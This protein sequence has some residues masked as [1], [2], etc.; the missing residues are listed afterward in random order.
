MTLRNDL[1]SKLTTR[2]L[3]II[4]IALI[5]AGN[6]FSWTIWNVKA[7]E[8]L[9]NVGALILVV[10]VLQWFFDQES[11]Q[12]L[13]DQLTSQIGVYLSRRDNLARLGATECTLDSKSLVSEQWAAELIEARTLAIG[14]HYSDG[15]IARFEPIIRARIAH[16][17]ITQI[18][19]SDPN[20]LAKPYLERC[21]SVSV[22]L[23]AKVAQLQ[24]LVSAR[25]AESSR[26]RMIQHGR[27]LRYSCFSG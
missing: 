6:S 18:L 15:M 7:H 16:N 13:I 23:A 25:F 3:T 4:G 2:N 22:D 14:I 24:Q 20:G 8:I 10:G 9:A 12:Y 27:V 11:R 17:K 5:V 1:K 26:I 21:L 19:H